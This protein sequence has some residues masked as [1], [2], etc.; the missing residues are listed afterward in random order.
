MPEVKDLGLANN[1]IVSVERTS[2]TGLPGSIDTYTITVRDGTTFTFNV[3]NGNNGLSGLS[4][5]AFSTMAAFN[6]FAIAHQ[7]EIAVIMYH[8]IE[9]EQD[10]YTNTQFV[11]GY[12]EEHEPYIKVRSYSSG[13]WY[14]ITTLS[15]DAELVVYYF[16]NAAGVSVVPTS[17][18]IAGLSLESDITK[19]A[20]NGALGLSNIHNEVDDLASKTNNYSYMFYGESYDEVGSFESIERI[21]NKTFDTDVI[22]KEI[23]PDISYPSNAQL[24]T[25][26]DYE[27]DLETMSIVSKTELYIFANSGS[28]IAPNYYLKKGHFIGFKGTGEGNKL[29]I[30]NI[31]PNYGSIDYNRSNN[32]LTFSNWR[33]NVDIVAEPV[34]VAKLYEKAEKRILKTFNFNNMV[35]TGEFTSNQNLCYCNEKSITGVIKKLRVLSSGSGYV[36]F[37]AVKKIEDKFVVI[38]TIVFDSCVAGVNEY[39][40]HYVAKDVYIAVA[41]EGANIGKTSIDAGYSFNRGERITYSFT[42]ASLTPTIGFDYYE[43]EP[44]LEED[45]YAEKLKKGIYCEGITDK[46]L[47]GNAQM[48]YYNKPVSASRYTINAYIQV[49][50]LWMSDGETARKIYITQYGGTS[51]FFTEVDFMNNT[52]KIYRFWDSSGGYPT[53]VFAQ[54]SLGFTIAQGDFLRIKVEKDTIGTIKISVRR[55][56]DGASKTLS[57]TNTNSDAGIYGGSG[58]YPCALIDSSGSGDSYFIKGLSIYSSVKPFNMLSIVGDSFVEGFNC[59]R[60]G[61]TVQDCFPYLIED[62]LGENVY[63]SAKGGEDTTGF[64]L[65]EDTDLKMINS[66][67]CLMEYGINDYFLQTGD[68]NGLR[69]RIM[70]IVNKLRENG[71]IPILITYV[72]YEW[73]RQVNSWIRNYTG[74]SYLDI[75]LILSYDNTENGAPESSY[76]YPDGHPNKI[77]NKRIADAF[78]DQFGYIFIK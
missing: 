25:I 30:K 39:D 77:G 3:T 51:C 40:C 59:I 48:L 58:D 49:R 10:Q 65:R 57:Y 62:A 17:R 16:E 73:L 13:S 19:E 26:Y 2:G 18:T 75:A 14:D 1:E 41:I 7:S 61:D 37:N 50:Y 53:T 34:S 22:I 36:Q 64:L 60:Y 8:Y 69:I 74:F 67:Y 54:E 35:N 9:L 70:K 28:V 11:I 43:E 6:T 44:K 23:R 66:K 21:V 12:D 47:V 42:R 71:V 5:Q 76:F 29:K 72:N 20:L 15:S 31:S 32:V 4:R 33:I 56:S 38:D 68:Y 52:L 27:L 24:V 46:N 55:T 78:I 45:D 63:V